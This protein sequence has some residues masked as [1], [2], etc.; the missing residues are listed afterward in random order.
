MGWVPCFKFLFGK[1][2]YGVGGPPWCGQNCTPRAKTDQGSKEC[3]HSLLK[4]TLLRLM[5]SM[6][7]LAQLYTGHGKSG[8]FLTKSST[9]PSFYLSTQYSTLS[10]SYMPIT[11]LD[12]GATEELDE[13]L[14]WGIIF[15]AGFLSW[16]LWME[17]EP[18]NPCK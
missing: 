7:L 8:H 9:H 5:T 1:R 12:I 18:V 17:Q 2:S 11:M 16:G 10:T 3:Y 13:C 15:K 14:L 6:E 4:L